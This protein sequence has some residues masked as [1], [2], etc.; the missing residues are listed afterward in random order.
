MRLTRRLPELTASP[1]STTMPSATSSRARAA[2]ADWSTF[3]SAKISVVKVWKSMISN[4]P[5]SAS[6]ARLTTSIPPISPKRICGK[7]TR[8]KVAQLPSPSARADS[9]S[10]GSVR[11]SA[12]ATGR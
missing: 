2:A 1:S 4:A 10:A 9:S 3:S 7:I 8:R 5:N 6:S 11:R 12:A